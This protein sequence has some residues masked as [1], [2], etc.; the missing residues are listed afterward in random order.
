MKPH[1]I[2]VLNAL[3]LIV[4]GLWG[5]Q[6]SANPSATA[7]IPVG[8]GAVFAL[9]TPSLRR[10]NKVVAHVVVLLTIVLAFALIMPLRGAITRGDL[11][12]TVRVSVML[13]GCIVALVVYA[14]SFIQARRSS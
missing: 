8:F 6:A 3:I 10:G 12:A 7:L 4:L 13:A 9:A 2:N 5:Y 14:Q 11:V 1:I